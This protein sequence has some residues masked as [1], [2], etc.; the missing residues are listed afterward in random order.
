MVE[1]QDDQGADWREGF[2]AVGAGELVAGLGGKQT[3]LSVVEQDG[4]LV[5]VGAVSDAWD[6]LPGAHQ[7]S[8]ER[9]D[10][11][12]GDVLAGV[13]CEL[14]I[15]DRDVLDGALDGRLR[16]GGDVE[17]GGG[18]QQGGVRVGHAG[19]PFTWRGLWVACVCGRAAP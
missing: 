15:L 11:V 19:G 7:Q 16:D 5:G 13:G 1:E 2:E 18:V 10:A 14:E 4:R 3:P 9:V 8:G 6:Q 17:Q 12:L